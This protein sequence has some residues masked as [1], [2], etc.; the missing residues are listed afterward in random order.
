MI[1]MIFGR[2]LANKLRMRFSF[3]KPIVTK[4]ISMWDAY[5]A[6]MNECYDNNY[7][8]RWFILVLTPIFILVWILASKSLGT[9]I[10]TLVWAFA[11]Y[12]IVTFK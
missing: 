8:V 2:V 3:I 6:K 7:V 10:F 1:D 11:A 5:I 9:S 4:I 12:R